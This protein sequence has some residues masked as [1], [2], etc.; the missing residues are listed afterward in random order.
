MTPIP[1]LAEL[2]DRAAVED[3]LMRHCRGV[4]RADWGL[5]ED[6]F[7]AD[8]HVRYDPIFD[9]DRSAYLAFLKGPDALGGLTRTMHFASTLLIDLEGDIAHSE[10][11]AMAQHT[12]TDAHPYAGAFVTTWLRYLDR[13]ERRDGEWRIADRLVVREWMRKDVAGMWAEVPAPGRR[14][15]SDPSYTRRGQPP[16]GDQTST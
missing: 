4:D 14:D 6:C 7:H 12:S 2:A 10:L 5:I 8:G 3:V 1:T 13:L 9:G 15:R 16:G 11:Y